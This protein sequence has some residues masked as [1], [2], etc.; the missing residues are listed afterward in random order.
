MTEISITVISILLQ[1]LAALLSLRLISTTH[2]RTAWVL[3]TVALVLMI[4]RRIITLVLL[5]VSKDLL[6]LDLYEVIGLVVSAFMLAGLV[7]IRRYLYDIFAAERILFE[8]E[9]R[10]RTLAQNIPNA[11]VFL[12]DRDHRYTLAEGPVLQQMG[13]PRERFEGKNIRQFSLPDE[14]IETF[15][16]MQESALNGTSTTFEQPYKGRTF[17]IQFIPI[18]N[19]NRAIAS[20]M[21]MVLDITQ[22]IKAEK[23]RFAAYELLQHTI[24]GVA[25]PVMVIGLD[26][27]I[28][29]MNRAI[30][31]TYDNNSS[32][33]PKLCYALSH[34][35]DAP[36]NDPD[37][38]C[39]FQQVRATLMPVTVLH[40]HQ[41][42]QGEVRQVEIIASPLFG[43]NGQLEGIIEASR[44]ITERRQVEAELLRLR[45][46]VESSGEVIFLTNRDGLIS[47]VNPGFTHLY[48]Y[49]AEEVV[50]KTTPRILKS[51]VMKQGDYDLLWRTVLNKQVFKGEFTN[52]AKDGRLLIVEA[53]INPVL[54]GTGD[55]DGFLAIQR[56]VT[57]RKQMEEEKNRAINAVE[58]S[59]DGIAITDKYDRFIY[60]NEA[61]AGI[62]GYSKSELLGKT[63]RCFVPKELEES[64][65]N[66]VRQTL[67][68]PQI[69]YFIAEP[70]ALRKDGSNIPTEVRAKALWGND[71]RYLGHICNVIDITRR[72]QAEELIHRRAVELEALTGVSAA[73]RAAQSRSEI[74]F[75]VLSQVSGLFDGKGTALAIFDPDNENAS[76]KLGL[77]A[78]AGWTGQRIQIAE[79]VTGR[80]FAT[81]L[82]YV[83]NDL[84]AEKPFEWFAAVENISSAVCLPLTTNQRMV[85]VLW[86]GRQTVFTDNDLSLLTAI[87][88]MAASALHRQSLH[89]D[90]QAKL[91]D[92]QETQLHLVQSE[93]LAAIG[94][95]ISGVAHELNNPLTSVVLYA[96]MMQRRPIDDGAKR[97]LDKIVTET[98]RA[99]KIVRGLLDFA[100][101]RPPESSPA[102]INDILKS[103]IDFMSYEMH[104]RNIQI[105]PDLSPDIPIVMAD[106]HQLQ[107][108][109]INLMS[110]AC[111]AISETRT[112]GNLWIKTEVGP[113]CYMLSPENSSPVIRV[114]VKD[115]GP[116]IREENLTKVFD[117]FFTTKPEGS[118]TGLG[119]SICHGIISEHGGN[120]WVESEVGRGSEFIVEL[121]AILPG[122]VD[123]D[124]DENL[125]EF[126]MVENS[127]LLI[128]DD[129]RSILEVLTRAL[130]GKGYHVDAVGSAREGL[131]K[132]TQ[133]D[134]AT[135]LCDIRMPGISGPDFYR[136]VYSRNPELVRRIVFITGDMVNAKTQALIKDKNILYLAKPFELD[137]LYKII[138]SIENELA[139]GTKYNAPSS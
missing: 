47:F 30:R 2:H 126:K 56:D 26:Y 14:W 53:S 97:D 123:A 66:N 44:D 11:A 103:V 45:K 73:M 111:Q 125:P 92:L 130:K 63:W 42:A 104:S 116:G 124:R 10:Y 96:Q 99:S 19:G 84:P 135:V 52:K 69:G 106:A 7:Y 76:I 39:P 37:H 54:D 74:F 68:N 41:T 112:E 110:N 21:A 1:V 108:V 89:E 15:A 114:K 133:I 86:L 49:T 90:L 70:L 9:Q 128:I 32:L 34:H 60:V 137:E 101:P 85:G 139:D 138:Q 91:Q 55:I 17:S 129:E 8:S 136:E 80:I 22:Q 122:Y 95:L 83:T 121:P 77:G 57:E 102:N 38:P 120:I 107:Q 40:E 71:G 51:G 78:W 132:M 58:N 43:E 100:R 61:H 93:K 117:P 62:Y 3:I 36:C 35:R 82:P 94:Q 72:K 50:G 20:G 105:E 59:I 5:D 75:A 134:Y 119:L 25:E 46:A 98:L 31:E 13:F 115:D 48:G 29:L 79:G 24:D 81:G 88:D 113:S 28:R 64:I 131:E 27:Q 65:A 67:H 16:P 23:E 12:F 4:A 33:T 118:G 87:A 109:F 127:H 6:P 18:K